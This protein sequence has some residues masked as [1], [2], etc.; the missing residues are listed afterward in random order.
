MAALETL[1]VELVRPKP[2]GVHT[3]K[4][5]SK[6]ISDDLQSCHTFTITHTY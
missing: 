2:S 1:W 3:Y 6:F 4:I 5:N